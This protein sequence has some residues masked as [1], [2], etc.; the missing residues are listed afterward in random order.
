MTSFDARQTAAADWFRTLRDRICAA[1]EAL[2]DD[3]GGDA[4]PGR[5]ERKS[6]DRADHTG[7]PGGGGTMS[8]MKG[9][10]FEK[11]GVNISTVRGAFDPEFAKTIPGAA[12]D[13]RFFATGISL[14]AHMVNPHVPAVH[15]NTR[16]LVTTKAWFGGGADLNPPIPVEADTADWHAAFKASCDRHDPEYF[17]RFKAWCDEY[18]FIKHRNVA[19]GQGGIFYDQLASGDWDAD[20]AFT[21]DVGET[22]LSIYPALVSRHMH[23]DWTAEDRARQLAYRGLYTEFNLVYDRGTLFGLK[24]GGNIDAILMSLPPVAT[25]S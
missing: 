23:D 24:T 11:V 19:R 14:V 7:A 4:A 5:F 1:F 17:P 22:F 25:W 6:W 18:F 16:Y 20:F 2:E 9:R 21:R 8:V 15:M 12:E 10:V 3:L 13:P